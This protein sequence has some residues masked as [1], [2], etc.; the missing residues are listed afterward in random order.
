M[1]IFRNS[2]HSP[3]VV[4]AEELVHGT[5]HVQTDCVVAGV[6]LVG[7]GM[8]LALYYELV[9]VQV[10]VI[11]RD[12]EIIAHVFAA[13]PLLTGHQGL[14][15]LFSVAGTYNVGACVSKELLHCLSQ[16]ADSGGRRLL[17]E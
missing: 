14:V 8:Y 10:P 15:Q 7:H 9:I 2:A 6:A 12:P 11:G 13:D 5:L 4:G 17:N 1:F 3:H 16:N